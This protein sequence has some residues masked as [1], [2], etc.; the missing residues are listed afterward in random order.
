[1]NTSIFG[2]GF[3]SDTSTTMI[4]QPGAVVDFLLANQNAKNPGSLDW[5]KVNHLVCY[6]VEFL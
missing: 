4:V 5:N 6:A 3:S 1:M 2:F